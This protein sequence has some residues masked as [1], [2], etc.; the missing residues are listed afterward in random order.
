[1][2]LD[3]I[4]PVR[5][6]QKRFVPSVMVTLKRLEKIWRRSRDGHGW[7]ELSMPLLVRAT[8]ERAARTID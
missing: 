8:T 7:F 5:G 1:L 3:T 2:S 6:W 4:F